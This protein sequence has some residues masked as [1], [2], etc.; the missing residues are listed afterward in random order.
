MK[1][2]RPGIYVRGR[3]PLV[4]MRAKRTDSY[5]KFAER[6]LKVLKLSGE[7]GK[8]PAIFKLNGA[9][10]LDNDLI[11]NENKRQWTLGNYLLILKKSA[12][13]IKMGIGYVSTGNLDHQVSILYNRK[14]TVQL[15]LIHVLNYI[16]IL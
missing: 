7:E 4:E 5:S 12:N 6:M 2:S 15:F 14:R 1:E 9:R 10:I 13:N 3:S 8:C 11:V 16:Y